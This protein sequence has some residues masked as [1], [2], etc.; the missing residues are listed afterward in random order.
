MI[1]GGAPPSC[2][3]EWGWNITEKT[4]LREVNEMA[5]QAVDR[6]KTNPALKKLFVLIG[7][8]GGQANAA[9]T[10]SAGRCRAKGQRLLDSRREQSRRP[11]QVNLLYL[12]IDSPTEES[13]LIRPVDSQQSLCC[14]FPSSFSSFSF[15]FFLKQSP[16]HTTGATCRVQ[17]YSM[18][19]WPQ[20]GIIASRSW[21]GRFFWHVRLV[22]LFFYCAS[23]GDCCRGGA[24]C[25][26]GARDQRLVD[27]M[28]ATTWLVTSVFFFFTDSIFYMDKKIHKTHKMK[29][30]PRKMV[31]DLTHLSTVCVS[32]VSH[33]TMWTWLFIIRMELS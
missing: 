27:D 7:R 14:F 15:F 18:T 8:L 3:G 4:C 29:W 32:G 20:C 10:S 2:D 33:I 30:M 22:S 12:P 24:V 19:W 28:L 21:G 5:V 31:C 11:R 13:T 25:V 6:F 9:A 16:L 1:S 17:L 26:G 23:E